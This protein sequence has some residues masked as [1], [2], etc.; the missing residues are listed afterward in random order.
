MGLLSQAINDGDAES[1]RSG[2]RHSF[3]AIGCLIL[4]SRSLLADWIGE[5]QVYL[6]REQAL[7]VVFKDSQKVYEKQ[8][9]LTTE[10]QERIAK[11][12]GRPLGC[13]SACILVGETQGRVDGYAMVIE[14]VGKFR[15]ITFIVGVSPEAKVTKVAVMVYRECRGSEVRHSR[16]LKQFNGK[17]SKN[18]I[19]INEDIVNIT[20][21][22]LSVIGVSAGVRKALAI[23]EETCIKSASSSDSTVPATASSKPP[24]P[25][26]S[27]T[28][29]E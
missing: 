27:R 11:H 8:V 22:T 4:M 28:S 12:F 15:P 26:L 24:G 6:D 10:Q 5:T 20:G 7:A 9:T 23:I 2:S 3:L 18:K 25:N 1:P 17:N 21:A 16:F 14:E 29:Q 19:R 13:A